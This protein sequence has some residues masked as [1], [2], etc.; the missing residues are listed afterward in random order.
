MLGLEQRILAKPCHF[1]VEQVVAV[2]K[3]LA[4]LGIGAQCE[5]AA[6]YVD[7]RVI[8]HGAAVGGCNLVVGVAIGLKQLAGG[9]EQCGTLPVAQPPQGRAA[10]LARKREACC[11]VK[12]AGVHANQFIAKDRIQQRCAGTGT[13]LPTTA[14]KVGELL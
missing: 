13:G 10:L 2:A 8:L 11:Q 14:E 9:A 7:G 6:V 3:R 4:H 5:D 1:A 12:P